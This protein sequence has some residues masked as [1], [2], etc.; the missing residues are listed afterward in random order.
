MV[1]NP[2]A[3]AG[4]TGSSPGPG[5]SH[6]YRACALEPMSHK[7]QSPHAYSQCATREVT[8]MRSP[9]TATKRSPHLPQLEKACT[10]QQRPNAAKRK[11]HLHYS[12]FSNSRKHFWINKSFPRQSLT[13]DGHQIRISIYCS[14]LKIMFLMPY[15][16]CFKNSTP[17]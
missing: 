15:K 14:I 4:D 13:S 6:N 1:K 12:I 11:S 3:N 8:A 10:Q 17:G 7:Y 16:I 2:P 5:R 9:C